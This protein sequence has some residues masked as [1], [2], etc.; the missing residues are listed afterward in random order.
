MKTNNNQTFLIL[1]KA[2]LQ[3]N[4]LAPEHSFTLQSFC[5]ILNSYYELGFNLTGRQKNHL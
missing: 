1:L 2:Q 5:L 4:D 3:Q